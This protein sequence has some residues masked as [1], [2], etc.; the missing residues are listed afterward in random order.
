VGVGPSRDAATAG[1]A[2]LRV[3]IKREP[4]LDLVAEAADDNTAFALIGR[5]RPDVVL[6]DIR[7]P[8][9]DGLEVLGATTSGSN[10]EIAAALYLGPATVRKF[11]ASIG[12]NWSCSRCTPVGNHGQLAPR[13]SVHRS[14]Q[15][16]RGASAP[17]WRVAPMIC[18]VLP[19]WLRGTTP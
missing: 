17:R 7:M 13:R 15:R 19:V 4:D 5:G 8:G 12:P 10:E 18:V 16:G 9:R 11:G 6:A 3:L 1:R 14:H 2:G